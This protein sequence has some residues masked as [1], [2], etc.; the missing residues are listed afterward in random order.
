[1]KKLYMFSYNGVHSTHTVQ[2]ERILL[3]MKER[4]NPQGKVQLVWWSLP[5][6]CNNCCSKVRLTGQYKVDRLETLSAD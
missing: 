3:D 2:W 1:M 6:V 5:A 4:K